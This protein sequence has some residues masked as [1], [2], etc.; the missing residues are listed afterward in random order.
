[1]DATGHERM[2]RE[3]GPMRSIAALLLICSGLGCST[4]STPTRGRSGSDTM[5]QRASCAD[6]EVRGCSCDDGNSG[7]QT[8]RVTWQTCRCASATGDFG[9]STVQ[10]GAGSLSPST[11]PPEVTRL[12][13]C[14]PGLYLGTYDCEL[15]FLG[16]VSQFMGEVSFNLEINEGVQEQ[17]D[18][19]GEFCA[20]LVIS[21][22]SGTLY[23]IAALFWGFEA[24]LRGGL[25]CTTGE[26]RTEP[27]DGV[28]GSAVS[29]DPTDPEALW[30][31]AQPA[32]GTFE[33]ELS[34]MHTGTEPQIIA[35]EWNL[36][37]TA[38]L[39]TCDGPF[40]VQLQ[41]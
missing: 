26:F 34:G 19:E 30:T 20:D 12:E 13:H 10:A 38:S 40:S 28:W 32:A 27:L 11:P 39:S 23:G 33:G 1:M 18:A 3:G 4:D 8:C 17:C 25:D 35:G 29:S 36:I 2:T 6:G 31:V 14:A 7:Q 41:P 9:N 37:E 15:D 21:E 24:P 22:G 16:A 5:A